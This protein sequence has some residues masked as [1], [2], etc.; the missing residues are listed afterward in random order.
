MCRTPVARVMTAATTGATYP[1]GSQ[2][3]EFPFLAKFGS[4]CHSY[5][6]EEAPVVHVD[7]G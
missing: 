5:G 7:V 2:A 3:S 1:Q 4:M 6:L